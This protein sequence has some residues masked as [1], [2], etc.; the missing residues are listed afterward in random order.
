MRRQW[1]NFSR[2]IQ[3][4]ECDNSVSMIYMFVILGGLFVNSIYIQW[5]QF[6]F[7]YIFNSQLARDYF[8]PTQYIYNE[9]LLKV[10][11]I[12][13]RGCCA[14]IRE[15]QSEIFMTNASYRT[16]YLLSAKKFI[17]VCSYLTFSYTYYIIDLGNL[18][19]KIYNIV[20]V[21]YFMKNLILFLKLIDVVLT[22][23]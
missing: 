21:I 16:C 5:A 17:K 3:M 6:Q 7:V 8:L 11:T 15:R 2:S 9:P 22:K 23:I 14:V 18:L 12:G 19:G 20:F 10:C 1:L 13:G 4:W